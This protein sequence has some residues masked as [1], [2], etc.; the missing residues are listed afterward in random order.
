M[1][2]SIERLTDMLGQAHTAGDVKGATFLANQIRDFTPPDISREVKNEAGIENIPYVGLPARVLAQPI[3]YEAGAVASV[4]AN[5][6]EFVGRIP[7]QSF[8]S[9]LNYF[10]GNK[11]NDLEMQYSKNLA[12]GLANK[13]KDIQKEGK[14]V[15][16]ELIKDFKHY[17]LI[18]KNGITWQ[19]ASERAK[20]ET[21]KI[22][23]EYLEKGAISD[24]IVNAAIDT[25]IPEDPKTKKE[26]LKGID[27]FKNSIAK[28][29][30]IPSEETIMDES[31]LGN[32]LKIFSKVIEFGSEEILQPLGVPKDDA[33]QIA[34][35]VSL[36]A[37]PTFSKVV[38]NFKGRIGYSDAVKKVY[39]DTLKVPFLKS[40]KKKA[41]QTVGKLQVE[42]EA[43]KEKNK[44]KLSNPKMADWDGLTT[45]VAKREKT[46]QEAT[47]T[48]NMQQYNFMG[49]QKAGS[50]LMPD[51]AEASLKDL[52]EWQKEQAVNILSKQ[53]PIRKPLFNLK[54]DKAGWEGFK[55]ITA[56]VAGLD[57]K[58]D[59]TT[60]NSI[61]TRMQN[62]FGKVNG[63]TKSRQMVPETIRQY[64]EVVD[65]LEGTISKS[66]KLTKE[67]TLLKEFFETIQK[68]DVFLTKKLQQEKIIDPLIKTEA[69]FFPRKFVQNR[70]TWQ[71]NIFG[72]RFRINLGDRAPREAS[73]IA[74]R[75]YFKLEGANKGKPIFI[76]LSQSNKINP[77]SGLPG[78]PIVTVNFVTKTG[79]KGSA[80]PDKDGSI[81]D[82]IAYELTQSAKDLNDG[83]GLQ[84]AGETLPGLSSKLAAMSKAS[85][86]LELKNVKQ[87][88]IR[89]VYTREL[90]VDPLVAMLES[91]NTKRQLLRESV[92]ARDIANSA[93]GKRNVQIGDILAKA[94]DRPYDPRYPDRRVAKTT[95]ELDRNNGRE[96]SPN[97]LR[98]RVNNPAL[99][100]LD[101]KK[102]SK[103]AA[104]VIED[105]FKE[106]KKGVMSK[107][108]D[109]LV[110]NMMLNPIPH[111]HNELVHFYSTKGFFGAM[112]K[113][114]RRNFASDQMWAMKQVF[115]R[116]PEY[117][118]MLRSGKSQ[119]SLNVIN[120]KN[121]D[122]VL[123]QSTKTLM[124]DT[125]TQKWYD[126]ISKG[127]YK[128]S[129]GY[130]NISD[131][132]QYSMWST[133]DVAYMALVK[134]KMRQ[135]NINMSDAA[136]QVEL[137]MPTYR[138][139]ETVGPEQ[140]LSYKVTRAVSKVLQNP[141][142][143]I[144][145]RYKHGMLSSGLNTAKDILSGLDPV[146][147]KLGKP[148]KLIAEGLGYKDIA[149]G[150]A[151]RK[152]FADG[153]DSGMALSSAW[154]IF[155]PIMDA[156]YTE[157]FDGDEVKARRAGFLHILETAKGV[158][159]QEKEITQLRNVLL[160]INPAFLL[161]YELW[162]NETQ[163]NSQEVY[164]FND[165]LGS[166][167]KSQFAKDIG[168]KVLQ[169]VPQYSTLGNSTDE[170]DEIDPKK[171]LG[172]QID[173]KIKTREQLYKQATRRAQ[174]DTINLNKAL[175]GGYLEE[176]LQEYYENLEYYPY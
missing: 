56:K 149:V 173:A 62:L 42:L 33:D 105:N 128:A 74:D 21:D 113:D 49:G 117:I 153:L 164:N 87:K 30:I 135:Q 120:S 6:P 81:Y 107:V 76:T 79:K 61:F 131:F 36:K 14:E 134:Q 124:G 140:I 64:N 17:D 83:R 16:A 28:S 47:E 101:G 123:R 162:M 77:K 161:M 152:Q 143:V 2:V 10:Q 34:A 23:E 67:Q 57:K 5:T 168:T 78:S 95:S 112:G 73:V 52:Y 1:T 84:R 110:K 103:R 176:Y 7:T 121:L 96:V 65:V 115:N 127:L 60:S 72:D 125:A 18:G 119:M 53:G 15:P 86:K 46:L 175:E 93:F 68:E 11:K 102:L 25:F 31:I 99:P 116:T 43:F 24:S 55:S 27:T 122:A 71:E 147:N 8:F 145:A 172:R 51:F 19:Q 129:K 156:L 171:F 165:L 4:I 114:G 82:Q 118:D 100:G 40:D 157:L 130:S 111:M 166:G 85:G 35:L 132:A 160:T 50:A 80:T 69:N 44:E 108:S 58:V 75:L 41:E 90:I 66:T 54:N 144:F 169:S 137:H 37:A 174:Q 63:F 146:L 89:D 26:V 22:V 91:V 159:H 13:I 88:E 20:I 142:M 109:A 138:L 106:Y 154:Y 48:F 12:G 29:N 155:Y 158:A 104:D 163:Y 97:Q 148:G 141:E 59:M 38:K 139:P 39:G 136:R 150:R 9:S 170:Y 126:G 32:A 167:S 70:S 92:Y 151:K 133:R 3:V 98:G 45:E 94:N